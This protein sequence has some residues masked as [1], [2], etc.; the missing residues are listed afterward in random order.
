MYKEFIK[1]YQFDNEGCFYSIYSKVNLKFIIIGFEQDSIIY[2]VTFRVTK[3][4]F[5]S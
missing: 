5:K 4:Y 3:N 1:L 2:I